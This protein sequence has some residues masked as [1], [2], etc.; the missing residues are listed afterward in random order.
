MPSLYAEIEINAAPNQVWDAL[1]RKENW[2][3]WNTFL[4]DGDPNERFRI[5]HEVFLAMQRI[6]GDEYTE[7]QPIVTVVRPDMCLR[8]VSRIPGLRTEHSFELMET[9]PG[10][11]RYLHRDNFSGVLSNVFLPFIRQDERQGLRRMADQ[12]KRYVERGGRPPERYY[13][14][15]YYGQGYGRQDYGQGY[16]DRDSRYYPAPQRRSEPRYRDYPDDRRYPPQDYPP[17]DYPPRDYPDD[18]RYPPQ[19]YPPRDYPPRD[20]PPDYDPP[21][22][23]D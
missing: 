18:R 22:R 16:D 23:R 2:R 21:R 7:F 11:T 3:Y 5:G 19:D 14:Q 9:A 1:M 8:W 17:R 4:F 13:E 15:D 10:R 6:E 12:L 20:Y